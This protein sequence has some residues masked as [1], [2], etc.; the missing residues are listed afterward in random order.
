[1]IAYVNISLVTIR[2]LFVLLTFDCFRQKCSLALAL[3]LTAFRKS[4]TDSLIVQFMF[5]LN[6]YSIYYFFF[7]FYALFLTNFKTSRPPSHYS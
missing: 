2:C 6:L 5:D 3:L 7:I 1:M 4:L